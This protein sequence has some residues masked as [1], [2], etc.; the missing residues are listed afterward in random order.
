[1]DS[2]KR[3]NGSPVSARKGLVSLLLPETTASDHV[4]ACAHRVSE[5]GL[6]GNLRLRQGSLEQEIAAEAARLPY[7]LIAIAAEAQG[8]FVQRVLHELERLVPNDERPVLVVKPM[9]V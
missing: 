9:A 3:K 7:D 6:R 1:V 4:A 5:A 2:G 8:D